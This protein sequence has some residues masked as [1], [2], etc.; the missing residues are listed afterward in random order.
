[1]PG[2]IISEV[3]REGLYTR[4]IGR[5]IMFFRE[6]TSTMDEA[7]RRAVAGIDD[8]T[9]LVANNQTAGRGR[10][11]R[12]WVSAQGNV[13]LTVVLRPTLQAL[14]FLSILGGVAVVRA[15]REATGLRTRIKWPNDVLLEGKK[16]AGILVESSVEG[17]KVC[18]ALL[19]IG[20][21]MALNSA[22][23]ERI[24]LPATSVNAASG[25]MVRPEELL[26]NVLHSLDDLY[27]HL[28]HGESP[29]AEWEDLLDTLKQR[30]KVSWQ[31]EEY[32]GQAEGVDAL[33]NLQLRL[34]N[35]ELLT[36]TTGDI[37]SWE[38]VRS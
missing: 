2:N 31:D 19:G 21:N 14:P 11:A 29:L 18:H 26:R 8:G 28:T 32:E 27:V 33:G 35:G 16:V 37:I 15:I 12:S 25:R 6:L 30:V 20:I 23:M 22:A 34:D 36:V 10:F 24:G 17:D 3:L 7:A 1:M 9:V 38:Q 13:Y 5:R 4:I